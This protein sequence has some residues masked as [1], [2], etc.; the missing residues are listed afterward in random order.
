[1]PEARKSSQPTVDLAKLM[2]TLSPEMKAKNNKTAAL[3]N[4]SNK[5]E[6][7]LNILDNISVKTGVT[8]KQGA[9]TR[10][11]PVLDQDQQTNCTRDMQIVSRLSRRQYEEFSLL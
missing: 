8:Y 6:E 4:G 3:R 10:K 11:A 2:K 1:M 9:T 5:P 7:Q